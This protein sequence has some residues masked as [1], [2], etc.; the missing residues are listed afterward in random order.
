M[1]KSGI[2]YSIKLDS[3]II[4]D[5]LI[6]S[7]IAKHMSYSCEPNYQITEHFTNRI[8]QLVVFSIRNEKA[9]KR[10]IF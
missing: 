4:I 8:L 9:K 6:D 1:Q 7:S 2:I 10:I 3:K 5:V